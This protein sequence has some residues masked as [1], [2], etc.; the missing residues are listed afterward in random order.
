MRKKLRQYK[1]DKLTQNLKIQALQKDLER[2]RQ[3]EK[4]TTSEACQFE[5]R[6]LPVGEGSPFKNHGAG[7]SFI[8]QRVTMSSKL[9]SSNLFKQSAYNKSIRGSPVKSIQ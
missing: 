1:Q 5:A 8:N 4:V 2:T 3:L 9:F 7:S 6:G